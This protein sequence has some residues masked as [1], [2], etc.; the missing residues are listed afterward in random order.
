MGVCDV[1]QYDVATD[2]CVYTD[3]QALQLQETYPI[4]YYITNDLIIII[5][6]VSNF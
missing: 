5:N 3:L 2:N 4:I 1:Q 6:H